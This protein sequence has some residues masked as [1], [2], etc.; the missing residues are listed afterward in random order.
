MSGKVQW[1]SC[2]YALAVDTSEDPV[3]GDAV[4]IKSIRT[5]CGHERR[6][7]QR[8]Y[9]S[10]QVNTHYL[11]TR[12]RTMSAEMWRQSSQYTLAVDTSEDLISGDAVAIKS[13][14]TVCRHK[15]GPYQGRCTVLV[16]TSHQLRPPSTAFDRRRTRH[17]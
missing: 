15:Q 17:P 3:S 2:Q 13:I 5:L 1:Q 8:R 9:S 7:C 16:A 4:E 6:P 14:R 12:A 10:N 11:W